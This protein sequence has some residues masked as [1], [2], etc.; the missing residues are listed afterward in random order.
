M[1]IF[2]HL[3]AILAA[4]DAGSVIAKDKAMK[5]LADLNAVPALTPEVTPI[6]FARLRT[7]AVNQVPMY[8]E[9]AAPTIAERDKAAFIAILTEWR[10]KIPMP[11]KQKRLDRVLKRLG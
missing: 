10:G 7:S 2:A 1:Q 8:A 3:D 5:L 11:A 6:L 9:F 4:A